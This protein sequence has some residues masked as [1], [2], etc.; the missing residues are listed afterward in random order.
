M[1][2]LNGA[3]LAL[4]FSITVTYIYIFKQ[5]FVSV[6]GD[7]QLQRFIENSEK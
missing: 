1:N 7:R 3:S 2:V 4:Y 6:K 5:E